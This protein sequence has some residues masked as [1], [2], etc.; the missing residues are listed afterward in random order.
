MML[1]KEMKV[2]NGDPLTF[3]NKDCHVTIQW[4][5]RIFNDQLEAYEDWHEENEHANEGKGWT[6]FFETITDTAM[7]LNIDVRWWEYRGKACRDDVPAPL[8]ICFDE[9]YNQSWQYVADDNGLV[10][11]AFE[12]HK[13]MTPPPGGMGALGFG[14]DKSEIQGYK[15]AVEAIMRRYNI[16][17]TRVYLNGLSY[18]DMS[19]LCY[20]KEYP[21]DLA[22]IVLMNGPTCPYNIGAYEL[23]GNLPALPAM[24]L[25]SDSDMT[26]DGFPNKLSFDVGDNFEWLRYVRS[27]Q[28]VYNRDLWMK[29]NKAEVLP[30]ITSKGKR[31]Y[32]KYDGDLPVI[33]NELNDRCH[34]APIDYAQVMW[35]NIYSVYKRGENGRI[36]KIADD[37]LI[38]DKDAIA[39]VVGS[40]KAYV[41]NKVVE[42]SAPCYM[43]E[44]DENRLEDHIFYGERE[45]AEESIY[46][47]V[48]ILLKGFGLEYEVENVENFSV[49]TCDVTERIKLDDSII[50]FDKND[51]HYAMYTN[52][53]IVRVDGHV[54]EMERPPL[55]IDDVLMIP[56]KEFAE[57]MSLF[58]SVRNDAAYVCDHYMEMGL[59]FSRLLREEIL[60]MVPIK[61]TYKVECIDAENGSFTVSHSEIPNGDTLIVKTAPEEGYEVEKVTGYMNGLASPVNIVADNEYYICNVFGDVV[62]DVTF[63]EA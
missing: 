49:W 23:M 45:T 12:Y 38:P 16:D 36:E 47:P 19:A 35:D 29:Q 57:F 56:V 24:T 53:C 27:K 9:Y 52:T 44:P 17:K 6:E 34:I 39:L 60:N 40:S 30:T 11:I 2:I 63:K 32:I 61:N 1:K 8:V 51:R 21:N 14:P 15:K 42:L 10:I 59:T 22:G 4:Y 5:D 18:G 33:Y 41:D 3:E 48:D 20:A 43:V 50:H 37:N 28:T 13:N 46:A 26:C 55:V 7:D 25:R 54:E 31:V 62:V 58:C